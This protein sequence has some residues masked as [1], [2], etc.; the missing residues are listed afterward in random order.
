MS[1]ISTFFLVGS[2]VFTLTACALFADEEPMYTSG[3]IEENIATVTA[4]VAAID[5]GSRSVSLLTNDGRSINF[6]AGPEV[7][8][9][10]RVDAGDVVRVSYYE[11]LIYDLVKPGEAVPG[12]EVAEGGARAEPGE[13]PAAG[14]ARMVTV[15]A[16][17]VA[18]DEDASLVTFES[19]TGG[20]ETIRARDPDR[21]KG[22]RIGDLVN[23]TY[24]QA[25]AIGVE[26]IEQ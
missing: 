10:D 13:K 17:V 22:V 19:S 2:L 23:F 21:L 11:S 4:K 7:R 18:I 12:I 14:V 16:T 1:R 8:N 24:T 5:H 26:E 15:T 9:L 25:V 3:T 20:R 6:R